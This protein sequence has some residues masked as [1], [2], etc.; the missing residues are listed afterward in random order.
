MLNAWR[1]GVML[2]GDFAEK[3]RASQMKQE[4]QAVAKK[5]KARTRNKPPPVI[6]KKEP[7]IQS[8]VRV[9]KERQMTLL[10]PEPNTELTLYDPKKN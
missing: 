9:E 5:E 6:E 8:S 10:D 7:V 1:Q 3:R 4:R 2:I